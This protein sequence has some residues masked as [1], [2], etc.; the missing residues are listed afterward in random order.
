MVYMWHLR[1]IFV[2]GMGMI[3]ED[4]QFFVKLIYAIIWG[5]MYTI[6]VVQWAYTCSVVD[7]LVKR[8][9]PIM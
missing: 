4:L 7:I 2:V 9:M 5:L 6:I 1:G 3:N 8:N